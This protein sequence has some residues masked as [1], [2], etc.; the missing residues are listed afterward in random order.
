MGNAMVSDI[1][2]NINGIYNP[3]LSAFQIDGN[4]NLGYTFLSL[5]RKLNF[6]GFTKNSSFLNSSRAVRE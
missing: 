5:D 6:L 1:F 4:V 3:A 2:G